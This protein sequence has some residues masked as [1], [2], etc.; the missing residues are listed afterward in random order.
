MMETE[1]FRRYLKQHGRKED[2]ADRVINLVGEF[3]KFLSSRGDTL[4]QYATKSDLDSF[5]EFVDREQANL[6]KHDD[7]SLSAKSYLW[8]M[9]Y[10]FQFAENEEMERYAALLREERIKRRPFKLKDFRGVD[11]REVAALNQ[12]GI[13]NINQMLK[14]GKTKALRQKLAGE[15]SLTEEGIV[16]LVRLSDLARIPGIKSIRARLYLDAGINSVE[17]MASMTEEEILKVTTRF[18]QESGFEGVPPLPAEVRYSIDKA[19]KLP[20]IVEYE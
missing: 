2:V 6:P 4:P 14:A 13:S 18:V 16:E 7:I 9:R 8:A 15:T 19:K 5:I 20:K 10:Y 11:S 3:I 17:K 12:H 1:S